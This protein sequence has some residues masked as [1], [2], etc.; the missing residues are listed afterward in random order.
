MYV[1]MD[2]LFNPE[3]DGR[4][5]GVGSASFFGDDGSFD[6]NN[7]VLENTADYPYKELSPETE[8]T[9]DDRL[10]HLYL[11]LK[12]TGDYRNV[13]AYKSIRPIQD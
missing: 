10:W 6:G 5:L 13:A 11:A 1:D 3:A 12:L 2:E 8:Q 7:H 4:E 9:I